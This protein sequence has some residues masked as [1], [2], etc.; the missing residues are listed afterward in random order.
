MPAV[1]PAFGDRPSAGTTVA[2]GAAVAAFLRPG[3]QHESM[4]SIFKNHKTG[5]FA[6]P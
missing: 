6:R 1:E 2:V 5:R 4:E 3:A